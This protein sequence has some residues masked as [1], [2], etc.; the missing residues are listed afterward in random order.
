MVLKMVMSSVISSPKEEAQKI[1][2]E[3]PRALLSAALEQT[4]KGITQTVSEG[5]MKLQAE[6][7]YGSLLEMKGKLDLKI[8]L[9]ELR[10]DRSE[11]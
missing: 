3:V 5:L 6:K 11:S 2:V 1:T 7:A 8:D 10:K 4:G 9:E